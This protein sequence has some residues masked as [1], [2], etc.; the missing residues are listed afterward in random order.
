MLPAAHDDQASFAAIFEQHHRAVLAY[1]LRR[2][3]D[4]ADAE[5]AAAEAFSIAWRRRWDLPPDPRPWL[6]GV[7][8]R[9][10]A[11]Q[12]RG[13]RRW[14]GLLDR[15]RRQP[16]EPITGR[17]T[18]GPALDALA[19]LRDDDQ[20]LLRLLAW[21]E[22][23]H[24]EI[25]VALGISPNAVAIRLHRARQ[26]YAQAY[27]RLGGQR[28]KGSGAGRTLLPVMGSSTSRRRHE[29]P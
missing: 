27:A 20:E 12:R 3:R 8:R 17:D 23:S 22:L 19:T 6:Y 21:E 26:R 14:A 25:A 10:L 4:A 5:D 2:T 18:A 13:G 1:C 9:V 16:P 15:L 29:D 28:L 7:A 11:N 24:A